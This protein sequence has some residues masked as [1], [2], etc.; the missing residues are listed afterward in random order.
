MHNKII[1][2]P[3]QQLILL[4]KEGIREVISGDLMERREEV[5]KIKELLKP[6]LHQETELEDLH[7]SPPKEWF[8]LGSGGDAVAVTPDWSAASDQWSQKGNWQLQ[9]LTEKLGNT[10]Q[11][12]REPSF[13]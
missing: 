3:K 7:A 11:R 6:E 5:S 10:H 4:D 9:N 1:K 8:K 2:K 12:A 13:G